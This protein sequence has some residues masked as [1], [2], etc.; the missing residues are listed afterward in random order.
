MLFALIRECKKI[1]REKWRSSLQI[2]SVRARMYVSCDRYQGFWQFGSRAPLLLSLSL[3][4]SLPLPLPRSA[5]PFSSWTVLRS[6]F[7]VC[8]LL[9]FLQ[10]AARDQQARVRSKVRKKNSQISLPPRRPTALP[11]STPTHVSRGT[12]N[13]FF[14]EP[15]ISY[16][17]V[18]MLRGRYAA[19]TDGL[20]LREF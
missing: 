20:R 15:R 18:V 4:Q 12:L 10:I 3:P 6:L 13:L 1:A 5:L 17:F 2:R 16:N 9:Q 19:D 7:C 8:S 14:R 11:T